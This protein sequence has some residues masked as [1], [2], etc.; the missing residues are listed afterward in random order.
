[1]KLTREEKDYIKSRAVFGGLDDKRYV[2]YFDEEE[3]VWKRVPA[4]MVM[5]TINVARG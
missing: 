3:G 2:S 4:D 5:P 1:M